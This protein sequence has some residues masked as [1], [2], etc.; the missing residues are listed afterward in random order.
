MD[1]RSGI[2]EIPEIS[3]SSLG[4]ISNGARSEVQAAMMILRHPKVR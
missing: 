1:T 2:L 4:H 3:D